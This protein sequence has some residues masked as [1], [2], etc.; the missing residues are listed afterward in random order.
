LVN[1]HPSFQQFLVRYVLGGLAVLV[2]W[3]VPLAL[4]VGLIGLVPVGLIGIGLV[5]LFALI[6]LF[7]WGK[8]TMLQA[9]AMF[10][11]LLQPEVLASQVTVEQQWISPQSGDAA[12]FAFSL[13][14]LRIEKLFV[15]WFLPAKQEKHGWLDAS[16]LIWPLISLESLTLDQAIDRL[17]QIMRENLI[18]FQPGLVPV[19]LV[20]R[21]VQWLL[22]LLGL[23]IGF[24][25][26][27]NTAS[28]LSTS[29]IVPVLGTVIGLILGGGFAILAIHFSTFIRACYYSMLYRWVKNVENAI[30]TG[31]P[32]K[33]A[34]PDILRQVLGQPSASKKER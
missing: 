33:A 23:W 10:D 7:I 14:G 11:S 26:G 8:I 27:M 22:I 12:L 24:V 25:V 4:I 17:K 2:L 13:P 34:P 29:G 19:V 6:S 9:V 20:V 16:Y 5:I 28:P 30:L 21:V 15:K 3:F 18:R 32:E 1:G 31:M